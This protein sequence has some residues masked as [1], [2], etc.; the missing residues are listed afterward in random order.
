MAEPGLNGA[1]PSALMAQAARAHADKIALRYGDEAWT[2]AEFD[3]VADRL[4]TAIAR[5]LEPGARA[6][7]LM[8]N[9]PEYVL[10]QCA[11]ER[12]G[13]IRVPVNA[14]STAHELGVILADCEPAVLFYDTTTADRVA[15]ATGE[16]LWRVQVNDAVAQGGPTYHELSTETVDRALLE[17]AGLDDL[18]SI[19]YTSGTSGRPK[20]AMLTHRNWAAVYRNML[21]DRDIR[22]EPGINISQTQPVAAPVPQN[23]TPG[24][25]ALRRRHGDTDADASV[26]VP[27][28]LEVVATE[29]KRVAVLATTID[30]FVSWSE[31]TDRRAMRGRERAHA[32]IMRALT[33]QLLE[34]YLSAR[35]ED[36]SA[37]VIREWI[38]RVAEGKASPIEAAR[39]LGDLKK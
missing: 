8:A 11:I 3:A 26:W 31:Q 17:R 16:G 19:N 20:G 38:D 5:R 4:A 18:S 39:M 25:A 10:L 27:P 29:N 22:G 12:A 35:G 23:L 32:Q 15:A 37:A 1:I 13:L 7:V 9:R 30:S 14:R 6:I 2:F 28:V 36:Q 34:P 21:I 24:M 33:A